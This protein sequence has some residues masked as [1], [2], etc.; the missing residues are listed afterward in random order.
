MTRH[1]INRLID[2]CIADLKELKEQLEE[3]KQIDPMEQFEEYKDMALAA[4]MKVEAA[5]IK[6]RGLVIESTFYSKQEYYKR[7]AKTHGITITGEHGWIKI[8]MPFLLPSKRSQKYNCDLLIDPLDYVLR[9]FAKED[10]AKKYEECILAF[11]HIY[12]NEFPDRA[13]RDHDN[14][15]IKKVIDII[16]S[17][18]MVDDSGR[19]CSHFYTSAVG[20]K[21]VTE[22]YVMNKNRLKYWLEMI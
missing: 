18:F 5:A 15:E 22:V 2:R 6:T 4:S 9:A 19:F 3:L 11:R 10:P 7:I 8:V 12:T 21:E 14:I 20:E 13:I 1:D 16:A 17:H